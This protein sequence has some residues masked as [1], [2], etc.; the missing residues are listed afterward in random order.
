M[1]TMDDNDNMSFQDMLPKMRLSRR[2]ADFQPYWQSSDKANDMPD[3]PDFVDASETLRL[4]P[5]KS[6]SSGFS[7][8]QP[9]YKRSGSLTFLPK[10]A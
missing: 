10:A 3:L 9:S 6:I 1:P 8:P 4:M 2:N 7:F 5:V